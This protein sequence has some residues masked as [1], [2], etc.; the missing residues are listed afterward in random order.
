MSEKIQPQHQERLGV[1]YIRQSSPG[2]VK[3]HPESYR[4]QKGL[5]RR[6]E[7]LGWPSEKVRVI[8]G[9]LGTTAS[10]PGHRG[11]FNELLQMVQ[12]QQVGI[13]LGQD[14]SR[15]ARN[16]IDW[17]LLTHWCALHGALIA[18][19]NQVLDPALPQDALVLG[20]QGAL[21][22]HEL[23]TI[24]R[25]LEDALHE[26]A[27]RGELQH[28]VPRG[29]VVVDGKHLKKHPDRR[30]QQAIE[31]VFEKF[32]TASSVS[33]L[34]AWLWEHDYKLPRAD[35]AGDGMQFEMVQ[36]GYSCLLDMLQNPKYAGLYV[37]P[38]YRCEKTTAADGTVKTKRRRTQPDEW[39]VR[40]EDHHPAYI[41]LAEYEANQEKIAMNAQ[42][43]A[44]A[45]RGA[46]NRGAALLGGLIE[47]RRC[48][49]IM[50]VSYSSQGKVT[51]YCHRGQRQ[52]ERGE[53]GCIRFAGEELE[54]QLS[55]QILYAVGPA[56]VEAARLACQRLAEERSARRSL[57]S[58]ELTQLRY[59]ADL[60]RRRFDNVDPANRLVLDTLAAELEAALQ[61]VAQQE[62]RLSRFDREEPPRPTSAEAAELSR[63]G[64]R[65]EEVWYADEADDRLKQQIVRVLLEN[66]LADVDEAT[67]E[68]VLWLHW[69]GGHHTELRASRVRQRGRKSDV[70]LSAVIDTLRKV[71]DDEAISRSL[72]RAGIRTERGETWT[73][74]RVQC[75]RKRH[76]IASYD[77]SLR[78]SS[79]W[80]TAS[81][82]ATKLEISPMSVNRLI[83]RGVIR[84]DGVASLPQVIYASELSRKEVKNAVQ[85]IKSH[86]NS[87]LPENPKQQ[88]LFQ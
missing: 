42:R 11:D 14:A 8:Q 10:L 82:A 87:P 62:S 12:D 86:G 35:A 21:A 78:A 18:D 81:E 25:R 58:D 41:T 30:V 43:F 36:A 85:Q 75:Y 33:R 49:H 9:D 88:T 51:Y 70:D 27:S 52:R 2:Q 79:G 34:L 80:L 53:P 20:I 3:N 63:L 83:Q 31:R 73:A 16:S 22:V 84:S 19:Q 50:Q 5:A 68:S 69:S 59:E 7:Q 13:V 55:E 23:H 71:S 39:T 65:L 15:L 1:V 48:H 17:S 64:G 37:Y 26:K 28:G 38:R 44:P 60:S 40:L 67:D 77:A 47:C 6:A 76:Q 54:R 24:R 74:G 56:G 29:Y 72:N 4:V 61:A 57:L 66:V 45:S 32:K 46:A